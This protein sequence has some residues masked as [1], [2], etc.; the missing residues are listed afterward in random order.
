MFGALGLLLKSKAGMAGIAGV[1]LVA[2]LYLGYRHYNGLLDEVS[3]LKATQVALKNGLDI[4]RAAV[5]TLSGVVE[6]W[7]DSRLELL[8]KIKEMQDEAYDARAETRRLH[9]LFAEID[10]GDLAAADLD[11]LADDTIDRLWGLIQAASDP[12][13]YGDGGEAGP[14]AGTAGSEPDPDERRGLDSDR[15]ADGA[16]AGPGPE[17][18]RDPSQ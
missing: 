6:D 17:A 5:I 12:S 9:E 2:A 18:V 15:D 14:E 13:G 3:N 8:Q 1:V 10:F 16:D 4:E 7:E 11:S